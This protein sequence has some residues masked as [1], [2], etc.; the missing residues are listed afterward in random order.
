MAIAAVG[1][2]LGLVS[3]SPS[4][5]NVADPCGGLINIPIMTQGTPSNTCGGPVAPPVSSG[6]APSQQT[7]TNCSGIPG[8]LSNALYGPGNVMVPQPN[9]K[10]QQSQ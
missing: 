2:P 5:S 4:A 7:L 8:C 9:T 1:I 3:T 6:G 10:V